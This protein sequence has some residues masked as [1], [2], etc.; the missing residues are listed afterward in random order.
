MK[1]VR[2]EREYLNSEKKIL[3]DTQDLQRGVIKK[4]RSLSSI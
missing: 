1:R 4:S 3:V 2:I